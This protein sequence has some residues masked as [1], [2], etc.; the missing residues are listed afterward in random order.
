[1]LLIGTT[2]VFT[3]R[4]NLK[5]ELNENQMYMLISKQA[6]YGYGGCY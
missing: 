3:N 5:G 4:L 2:V 6:E 1:M